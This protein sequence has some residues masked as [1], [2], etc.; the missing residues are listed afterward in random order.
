[1]QPSK[2]FSSSSANASARVIDWRINVQ[3]W[4]EFGFRVGQ[5]KVNYNREWVDSSGRQQF[6][7]RSIVNSIQ[8]FSVTFDL[9]MLGLS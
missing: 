7:E 9:L 1:M 5:W 6:V 3:P 8:I 2:T 4:E